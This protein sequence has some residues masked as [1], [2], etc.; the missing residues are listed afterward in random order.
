M[1]GSGFR[2]ELCRKL[3]IDGLQIFY[4]I[5]SFTAGYVYDVNNEAAAINVPE[6]VV[7]KADTLGGTFNNAGNVCHYKALAFAQIDN[8]QIG[9]Q[10]S[11][12]IVGDFRMGAG[13]YAQQ[14]RFSYIGEAYKANVG[15][16]LQ[17][18][19][20][21]VAFAGEA[22]LGKAGRLPGGGR[23]ALIAPA[24]TAALGQYKVLL[25]RHVM[26]DL[27][28]FCIPN[29]SA[30][31]HRD[32]QVIAVAA[33]HIAATAVAAGLSGIFALI[34]EIHQGGHAGIDPQHHTATVT[35]ITTVRAASGD[36]LFTQEGHAAV[37]AVAGLHEDPYFID[38]LCHGY[39]PFV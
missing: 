32:D 25:I 28:G 9:E 31:R 39:S 6:K 8:T 37:A 11:K 19:N 26:D 22:R 2:P 7:A 16:Q 3:L 17:L 35:A 29:H 33:L 20:D 34:A 12:V 14:C 27:T 1:P 38:K 5:T 4:G 30:Q 15:Q 10:C 21:V 24:A 36:I 13:N 18:Q 23:K